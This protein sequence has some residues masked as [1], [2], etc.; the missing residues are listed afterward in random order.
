MFSSQSLVHQML[1]NFQQQQQAITERDND[2]M[3]SIRDGYH[4][5][6]LDRDSL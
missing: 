3:F 2:L 6:R 1:E 4:G 5:N